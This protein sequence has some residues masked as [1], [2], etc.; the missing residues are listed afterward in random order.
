[1]KRLAYGIPLGAVIS[2]A[3]LGVI[4]MA[5]YCKRKRNN[6]IK[7]GNFIKNHIHEIFHKWILMSTPLFHTDTLSST[8]RFHTRTTPF[9][10]PKSFSTTP[11]A[12]QFHLPLNSTTKTEEN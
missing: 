2:V 10:Q 7:Q 11:K 4:A 8:H 1:M 5:M 3:V 12:S 9:Q 6:D